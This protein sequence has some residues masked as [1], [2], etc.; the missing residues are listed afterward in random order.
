MNRTMNRTIFRC[1]LDIHDIYSQFTLP[2]KKGDTS[3]RLVITL[4]ENGKPYHIVDGCYAIFAGV[5]ANGVILHNACIVEKNTIIYDISQGTTS[6]AGK[7]G[8]EIILYDEEGQE[9]ISPRFTIVVHDSIYSEATV[10]ESHEYLSLIN[11]LSEAKSMISNVEEKLK[12][13]E[14]KG[15]RGDTGAKVISTVLK[16]KDANG[17]YIYE[18]T[19]DDGSTSTFISP[20]GADGATGAKIVT[21]ELIGQDENGGNIYE[22]TFDNGVKATFTAPKGERGYT[23]AKVISTEL[24]GYD[25]H[26]NS[27][28]EQ[29]FD[30]GSTATFIALKGDKGDKGEAPTLQDWLGTEPIGDNAH[31]IYYDGEKFVTRPV[32]IKDETTEWAQ[33]ATMADMISN[34]EKTPEQ[35]GLAVGQERTI[36]LT[37]GEEVTLQILGFNHD[38]LA[39]GSGKKAGITFGMKNLMSYVS[40]F[41]EN[42]LDGNQV[43]MNYSKADI[44]LQTLASI[45][46]SLPS[47]L[48]GVLK[49]VL[50]KCVSI[51]EAYNSSETT[52]ETETTERLFLFSADE[53]DT[54]SETAY[55][56]W[57]GRALSS[58]VKSLANGTSSIK[59]Y[60]VRDCHSEDT[61]AY[62]AQYDYKHSLY[63]INTNGEKAMVG[64]DATGGICF[65]F[66][67]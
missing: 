11:V 22:Q 45:C 56:Y 43:R 35:L 8:S 48:F 58:R 31:Y 57:R 42:I 5:K 23:G 49:D 17:D 9:L 10:E 62:N 30:D 44:R 1:S 16:E 4:M 39:D 32:S 34:G 55:E 53:L 25:E 18:Q 29:T 61:N 28:Y 36:T 7:I 37:T 13:G 51:E 6:T 40:K 12:N 26:G 20:K 63:A 50:K 65:G 3:G 14:L 67:I 27:I 47:D 54:T 15:D 59:F 66:C 64:K 52:Y 19:F 38:E 60:F 2:I 46:G 33:I 41:S 24:K 21:T